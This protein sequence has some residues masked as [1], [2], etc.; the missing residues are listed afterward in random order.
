MK[1]DNCHTFSTQVG[2]FSPK[3]HLSFYEIVKKRH[4]CV[5]P[6]SFFASLSPKIF[7]LSETPHHL[8]NFSSQVLAFKCQFFSLLASGRHP[9]R[10]PHFLG[11]S[12]ARNQDRMASARTAETEYAYSTLFW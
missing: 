8:Y 5:F 6:V 1:I 9:D 10:D 2:S 7:I 3:E 4:S 11:P 12:P